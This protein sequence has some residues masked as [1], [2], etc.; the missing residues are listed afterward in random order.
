[1]L[2]LGD[3][4]PRLHCGRI[5]PVGLRARYRDQDALPG[6]LRWVQ[7]AENLIEPEDIGLAGLVLKNVC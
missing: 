7:A 2:L 3:I 5:V 1:M 6:G 4:V